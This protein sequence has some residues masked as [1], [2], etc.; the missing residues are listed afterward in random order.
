MDYWCFI[1]GL[2]SSG[3]Y[4]YFYKSKSSTDKKNLTLLLHLIIVLLQN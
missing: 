4:I 2:L 3:E 1:G